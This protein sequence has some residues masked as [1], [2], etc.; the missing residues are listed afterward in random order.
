MGLEVL[1]TKEFKKYKDTID[2]LAKFGL[3]IEDLVELKKLKEEL[4]NANLTEIL[5]KQNEVAKQ[6]EKRNKEKEANELK[7]QENNIKGIL[8]PQQIMAVFADGEREGFYPN[9]RN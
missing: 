6:E 1:T 9:G 5:L 2:F 4:K 8:T 3:T 7:A